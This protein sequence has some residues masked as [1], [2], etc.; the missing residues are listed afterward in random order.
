VVVDLPDQEQEILSD[1]LSQLRDLVM[2]DHDPTLRRLKPPAHPGDEEAEA[3]YREMV[4][5]QLLQ[6]RLESIERVEFGLVGATLDESDTDA[7]MH[8]LNNM[9]LILGER[10]SLEGADLEAHEL[11]G[12]TTGALYE[13]LGALL[14]QLVAAAMAS[15]PDGGR[16]RR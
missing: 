5:D 11:G 2:V 1:L 7:W 14:E 6:G 10:L 8:T 4:D 16:P 15:R 13:W 12:G 3:G 9:R